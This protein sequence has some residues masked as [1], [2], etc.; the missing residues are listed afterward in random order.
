MRLALNAALASL[1]PRQRAVVVR[2]QWADLTEE[3]TAAPLGCAAG[4]VKSRA[5]KAIAEL[6][7]HPALAHATEEA[8][9]R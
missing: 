4:T 8:L 5:S 3:Q 6:G 7:V 2:R 1:L 9:D